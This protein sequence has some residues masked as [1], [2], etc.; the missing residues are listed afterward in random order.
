MPELKKINKSIMFRENTGKVEA[1]AET[2][3]KVYID[4]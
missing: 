2:Q 1:R 3:A 4:L